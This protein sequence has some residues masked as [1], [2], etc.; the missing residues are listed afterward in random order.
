MH[1]K[2]HL[3]PPPTLTDRERPTRRPVSHLLHIVL[4]VPDVQVAANY[5]QAVRRLAVSPSGDACGSMRCPPGSA[6]TE[7]KFS[8]QPLVFHRPPVRGADPKPLGVRVQVGMSVVRQ[9]PGNIF[10]GYGPETPPGDRM[11]IEL[12]QV[13]GVPA[14]AVE[15][16]GGGGCRAAA[17]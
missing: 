5:Y 2:K 13:R 6:H 12:A 9:R 16:G 1:L 10:V 3:A 15:G 17:G 11:V 8:V 7:G 14:V 4:K